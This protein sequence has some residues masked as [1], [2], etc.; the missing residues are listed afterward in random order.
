MAEAVAGPCAH[1]S[2]SRCAGL[3]VPGPA[4]DVTPVHSGFEP[5]DY[6]YPWD[7]TRTLAP[8][9]RLAAPSLRGFG[10]NLL[11]VIRGWTPKIRSL[12]LAPLMV[13]F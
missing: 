7:V 12:H 11:S 13:L 1:R 6:L 2:V 8:Y 10:G 9:K 5:K 3:G 4:T